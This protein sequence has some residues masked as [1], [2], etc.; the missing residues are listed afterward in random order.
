MT[1]RLFSERNYNNCNKWRHLFLHVKEWCND[2][3]PFLPDTSYG[4]LSSPM[5]SRRP[6]CHYFAPA[7]ST[8]SVRSCNNRKSVKQ[9]AW[10]IFSSHW[11]FSVFRIPVDNNFYYICKL[12]M[13]YTSNEANWKQWYSCPKGNSL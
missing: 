13:W 5:P 10:F 7:E 2:S 11:L 4:K 12:K 3:D 9:E 1:G 6:D 8:F